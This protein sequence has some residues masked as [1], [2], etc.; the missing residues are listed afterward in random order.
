M[1]VLLRNP[2]REVEI[3]GPLSV[4]KLLHQLELNRESVLI[5]RDSTLVPADALLADTDTVEITGEVVREDDLL[6]L[7]ADPS[8]YRRVE[9]SRP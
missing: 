8:G 7:R 6:F 5:I 3:R 2:R 4:A 9:N 1:K